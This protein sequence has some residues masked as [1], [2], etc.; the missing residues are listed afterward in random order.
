M[1]PS[2]FTH[3]TKRLLTIGEMKS[4]RKVDRLRRGEWRLDRPSLPPSSVDPQEKQADDGHWAHQVSI[5]ILLRIAGRKPYF[6]ERRLLSS[7]ILALGPF[8]ILHR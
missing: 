8:F 4:N 1:D 6:I 3:G 5:S 2:A 7:S